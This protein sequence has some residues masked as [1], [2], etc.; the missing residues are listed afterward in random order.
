MSSKNLLS[1]R[2][3][4]SDCGTNRAMYC[5]RSIVHFSL[6]VTTTARSNRG[7]GEK[8]IRI[9]SYLMAS[10]ESL[11]EILTLVPQGIVDILKTVHSAIHIPECLF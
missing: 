3:V 7:D 11:E 1:L 6:S 10:S 9:V 8:K 4:V 2:I 5:D